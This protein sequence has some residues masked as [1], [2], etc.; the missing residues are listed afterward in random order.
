[1]FL[2]WEAID[3]GRYFQHYYHYSRRQH[4]YD[5]AGVDDDVLF[6]VYMA[7]LWRDHHLCLGDRAH[8]GY[9]QY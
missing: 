2:R 4:L 7:I 1:M 3:V 6:P 5:G 8:P 9:R